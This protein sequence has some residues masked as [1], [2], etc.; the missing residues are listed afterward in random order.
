MVDICDINKGDKIHI[1]VLDD[2]FLNM[3]YRNKEGI[4]ER[5]DYKMNR[6][7]GSWGNI[8]LYPEYDDISI[9]ESVNNE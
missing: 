1:N 6:I 3:D 5:I 4:V 7:F 8:E 9:I 2:T